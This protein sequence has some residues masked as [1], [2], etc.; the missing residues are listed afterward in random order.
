MHFLLPDNLADL[1]LDRSTRHLPYPFTVQNVMWLMMLLGLGELFYRFQES[2]ISQ[3]HLTQGYLPE[4]ENVIMQ[5]QDVGPVYKRVK[6][7]AADESAYLPKM[8]HQVIMQFQSSRS[9]EQANSLLNSQLELFLHQLEL[10][11]SMIRY[12][13]WLIPTL[14]FIGTVFGISITLAIAGAPGSQPDDPQLLSKL[15]A[16]LA[17]A[18]NTTL[19]AL[20]QSAILVYLMH[21]VEGREE[22]TL[23]RA[24][25]YCLNNLV[26]R[27]YVKQ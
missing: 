25:Q 4:G 13:T 1:L 11:Y 16:G 7:P 21:I 3:F 17:V 12:L 9:I 26:N 20:V 5:S 6:G 14:G 22:N 15:T 8:I 24:G 23:N 19:L 10:K 18:F 27:L 2:R